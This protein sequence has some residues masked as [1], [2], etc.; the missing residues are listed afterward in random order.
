MA[1]I[2]A[3][4]A[5]SGLSPAVA[6]IIGASVGALAAIAGGVITAW[7]QLRLERG[8][9][10]R[11]R[12]EAL[13]QDLRKAIQDLTTRMAAALHSM[14]WLTWSADVRPERITRAQIDQYD[15][16]L[17]KLLP[18]IIGGL[19]A[20]AALDPPAFLKLS[21][22]GE[23]IYALDYDVGQACLTLDIEPADAA[24]KLA[25]LAAKAGKLEQR[26]PKAVAGVVGQRIEERA[27]AL[28]RR[29]LTSR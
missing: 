17:H 19:T 13:A 26:L 12:E 2:G 8:R 29:R 21:P 7:L 10:P 1:D 3:A 5:A 4:A 22:L 27:A 18:E 11:A 24:R 23:E 9:W 25:V 20:V 16:E 28:G 14:C 15:A 6:T